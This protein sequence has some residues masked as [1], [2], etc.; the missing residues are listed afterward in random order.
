MVFYLYYR[1]LFVLL[2]NGILYIFVEG[3]PYASK[4]LSFSPDASLIHDF[5]LV[6]NNN[7][8]TVKLWALYSTKSSSK[9]NNYVGIFGGPF[10]TSEFSF[11]LPTLSQTQEPSLFQFPKNVNPFE[12]P[13]SIIEMGPKNIYLYH[14]LETST[15]LTLQKLLSRGKFLEADDL[16]KKY[17]KDL[18]IV[19]KAEARD[20]LSKIS[21]YFSNQFQGKQSV[22]KYSTAH[23][24]IQT[25][26]SYL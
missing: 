15:D 1:C 8:G 14:I 12:E 22:G 3:S 18:D 7:E 20:K 25:I 23:H 26:H 17:K 24:F 11:Q 19:R 21:A 16:A 10:F 13:S 2:S 9:V 6:R 5:T 4:S